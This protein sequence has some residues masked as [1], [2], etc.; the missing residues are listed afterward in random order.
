MWNPANK[1]FTTSHVTRGSHVIQT[2]KRTWKIGLTEPKI[3]SKFKDNRIQ[4]EAKKK[5]KW[6]IEKYKMMD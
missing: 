3:N 6:L 2:E 5:D 1:T 4:I